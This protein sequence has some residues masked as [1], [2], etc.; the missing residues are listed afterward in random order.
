M[1]YFVILGDG[2][3]DYPLPEKEGKTPLMLAKKPFIDSLAPYSTVGL[4]K[5]V[6]EGYKP[7]SDV[8][9]LSVMGYNPALYYSGRSPLEAASIGINLKDTDVTLR[10][11]LV[12]LSDEKNY[13]NKTMVDYSAGEISTAEARELIE[14]LKKEFDKPPFTLYAGISYRHCLVVDEGK[15]GHTLTP[16]H[17]ISDKKITE[18]L[19]KGE[20]SEAFLSLMKRSHEL[21][22]N[23][24]VNLAR[25]KAGKNP[26]NS[27]W[28]WGEGT[29]PALS[30]F[31]SLHDKKG[32]VISAVD[33]VKGIGLLADMQSIEVEGATGNW[34]TNF[35]GKAKACADALLNGL[36]FVYVHMEAPDE[37]GHHGD[38]E[39]K[40]FS[41][42]QIDGV[43]KY[44]CET[45]EKA[46]E[47]Y[48][49]LLMPDHPTPIAI[50]T[51]TS[52]AVPFLLY[53]STQKTGNGAKS[54]DEEEA[55]ATQ[56]YVAEGFTLVKQ[57]FERK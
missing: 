21:L 57:L 11:N 27:V 52:D 19:P 48:S 18:Y 41:I 33:L 4:A 22:K 5:T 26:A 7:G 55:K 50:K 38:L 15:T 45:L 10:C 39:K 43:V 28:F 2:M 49:L 23:H 9:N 29:K 12:T 51:H 32:A 13:E 30:S 46:G 3:A 42:E 37:C 44:V 14:F 47:E 24:P 40:I 6:P 56:H 8:A 16:P 31:E 53:S 25:I 36:D 34:D 17:D 54:Y 1:K 20:G 35:T